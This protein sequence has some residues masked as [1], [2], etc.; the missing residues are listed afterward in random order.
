MDVVQQ[1]TDVVIKITA[2]YTYE[3]K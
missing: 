3:I 2:L 1:N